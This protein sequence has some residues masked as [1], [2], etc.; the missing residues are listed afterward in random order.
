MP[1][2][3]LAIRLLENQSWVSNIG[4]DKG[5]VPHGLDQLVDG[6]IF[7]DQELEIVAV[8][9]YWDEDLLL[10]VGHFVFFEEERYEALFKDELWVWFNMFYIS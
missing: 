7:G 1:L 3:L 4:R 8:E 6:G 9:T 5:V 10:L 2:H